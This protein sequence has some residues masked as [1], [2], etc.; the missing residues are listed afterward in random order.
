MVVYRSQDGPEQKVFD[1]LQCLVPTLSERSHVLDK[2]EQTVRS[3]GYYSNV[4]RGKRNGEDQ[5][6]FIGC[7]LEAD[8]SKKRCQKNWDRSIPLWRVYT[9]LV[10]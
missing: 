8:V 5:D 4:S 10:D 7:V 3:Y 1:A 9:P 6:R 2:G